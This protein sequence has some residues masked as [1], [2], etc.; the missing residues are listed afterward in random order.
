MPNHVG[1]EDKYNHNCSNSEIAF[2]FNFFDQG[3][4]SIL[5]LMEP[6]VSPLRYIFLITALNKASNPYSEMADATAP[7]TNK[8]AIPPTIPPGPSS[9]SAAVIAAAPYS[10]VIEI[11]TI[12]IIPGTPIDTIFS[13][14]LSIA[15]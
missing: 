5:A 10:P 8:V 6:L 13:T 7:A 1:I 15:V 2:A 14:I 9:A 4:F 12:N 3:P 11:A